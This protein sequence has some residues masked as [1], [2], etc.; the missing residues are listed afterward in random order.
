M[1]AI[2][3]EKDFNLS[4]V[5]LLPTGGIKVNY[6]ITQVIEGEASVIDRDE[7]CDRDVHPDLLGLFEDLRSIVARVFNVTAFL[8]FL[9]SPEMKLPDAKKALARDFADGLLEKIDVRGVSWSGSDENVGVV[10]TA[11]METPNGLKSMVNTPR[12]KLAQ[13][14]FGF[15]E[16]LETI[17]ESI[18]KEVYAYLFKGKQAQLSLFG[19][20][21]EPESEL[22]GQD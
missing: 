4:K 16:E 14:S 15:E 3:T 8:S 2:P 18:K 6:Q 10:V 12:I 11:V 19:G 9:E 7:T 22:D 17:V 5:K 21:V 13:I 1:Q 20:T